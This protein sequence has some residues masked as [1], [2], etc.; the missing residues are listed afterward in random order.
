MNGPSV[1]AARPAFVHPDFGTWRR[2]AGPQRRGRERR[3]GNMEERPCRRR[4]QN[5][6]SGALLR[7]AGAGESPRGLPSHR[8][9]RISGTVKNRN[10]DGVKNFLPCRPAIDLTE[11]VRTH[12]PHEAPAWK[13]AHQGAQCV[14][15]QRAGQ[16]SLQSR[17]P[18]PRMPRQVPG[19]RQAIG[20]PPHTRLRLQRILRTYQPPDL[21]QTQSLQRL[22]RNVD[23][24]RVCGIEGPAK[25]AD[26]CPRRWQP[27]V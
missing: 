17:D 19:P 15:C 10:A 1:V 6:P 21:I 18:E 9:K 26:P 22:H 4:C 7:N 2:R 12:Q 14:R 23:V 20:Q 3:L 27:A 25:Q 11:V 24:S 5:Q 8:C 13:P 16:Q